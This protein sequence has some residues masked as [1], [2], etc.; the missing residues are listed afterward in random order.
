MRAMGFS[1]SAFTA[2]AVLLALAPSAHAQMLGGQADVYQQPYAPPPA[3]TGPGTTA[4]R[5]FAEIGLGLAFDLIPGG[6]LLG[7]MVGYCDGKRVESCTTVGIA[8]FGPIAATVG[9]FAVPLGVLLAGNA[10]GGSGGYGWSLIG[11]LAGAAIGWSI[12]LVSA[13]TEVSG[14][15][16]AAMG[17]V[18][19]LHV[20]GAILGY[21][22]ASDD[23]QP[24]PGFSFAPGPHG[25]DTRFAIAL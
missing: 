18:P 25:F 10:L 20:G 24:A 12:V 15:I 2:A 1:M 23:N 6:I 16:I 11:G 17:L 3:T 4:G 9:A 13:L 8:I 5:V 7:G 19:V 22:L 14:L 21:E